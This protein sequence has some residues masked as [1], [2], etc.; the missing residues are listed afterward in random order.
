MAEEP[1]FVVIMDL[2][3]AEKGRMPRGFYRAYEKLQDVQRLQ[4]SVYLVTGVT[5]MKDLV[6]LARGCGF[7][8]QAFEVVKNGHICDTVLTGE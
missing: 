2:L 8:V 6:A 7:Q 5:P 3:G 4:K 1:S